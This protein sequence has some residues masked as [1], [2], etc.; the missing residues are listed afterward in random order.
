MIDMAVRAL[1]PRFSFRDVWYEPINLMK[2][3]YIHRLQM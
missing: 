1:A 3:Y 2:H